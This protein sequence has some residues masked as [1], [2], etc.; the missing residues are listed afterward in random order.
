MSQPGYFVILIGSEGFLPVLTILG[1][2][3]DRTLAA[4]SKCDTAHASDR[5]YAFALSS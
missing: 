2:D 3:E 1:A 4:A 5:R